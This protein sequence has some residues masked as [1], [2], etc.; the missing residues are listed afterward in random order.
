MRAAPGPDEPFAGAVYFR[1]HAIGLRGQLAVLEIIPEAEGRV[2]LSDAA[3]QELFSY[4][5]SELRVGRASR[6]TFRVQHGDE[7]WWL[8]GP[9]FRSG[10]EFERVRQQIDRDDVV[11]VV[12]KLPETDERIYNPLMSNLTAEQQAWCGL[13]IAAL[14]RAGAKIE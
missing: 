8:S 4:R 5:P 6:T 7:R 11:L 14:R 12:P 10:K 9:S 3:G 1:R 2:T 13:W